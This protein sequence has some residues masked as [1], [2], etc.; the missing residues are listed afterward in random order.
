MRNSSLQEMSSK[1]D[2]QKHLVYKY[3]KKGPLLDPAK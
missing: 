1:K 3:L 2:I